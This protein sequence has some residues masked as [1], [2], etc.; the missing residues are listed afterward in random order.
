VLGGREGGQLNTSAIYAFIQGVDLDFHHIPACSRDFHSSDMIT[1]VR[2]FYPFGS[3]R[4]YMVVGKRENQRRINICTK[5]QYRVAKPP[6]GGGTFLP[7]TATRTMR[8][9]K[10]I[11]EPGSGAKPCSLI[12]PDGSRA[13][14]C[15]TYNT[16]KRGKPEKSEIQKKTFPSILFLRIAGVLPIAING[17]CMSCVEKGRFPAISQL[18]DVQNAISS[19]YLTCAMNRYIL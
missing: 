1:L 4:S 14:Q 8:S 12:P 10:K 16:H 6:I 5:A 3:S 11:A 17:I 13:A 15:T 7:D 18:V 19:I 2:M 9:R